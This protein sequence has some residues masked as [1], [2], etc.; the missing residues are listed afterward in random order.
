M[1][2][3]DKKGGGEFANF[4]L[5]IKYYSKYIFNEFE[6]QLYEMRLKPSLAVRNTLGNMQIRICIISK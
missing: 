5:G 3:F 1:Y 4:S 2:I 6:L